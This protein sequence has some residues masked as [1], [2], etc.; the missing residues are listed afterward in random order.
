M[1]NEKFAA[2]AYVPRRGDVVW[3]SFNPQL[4]HEQAGRRPALVLS[5]RAYNE[6]VGLAIVC[7]ITSHEKGYPFEVRIPVG[8]AVSGT[9]LAD[10]LKNLDWKARQADFICELP[11]ATV[12]EVLRKL[13]ALIQVSD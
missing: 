2:Y 11:R 12:D 5:P 7:P 6:K 9:I 3:V 4:G 8:T 13:G 10:Q 1:V